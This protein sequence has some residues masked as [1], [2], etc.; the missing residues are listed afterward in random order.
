VQE[1]SE[2]KTVSVLF[3]TA[4]IYFLIGQIEYPGETWDFGDSQT[5]IPVKVWPAQ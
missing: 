3:D 2:S 1:Y 4:G 5:G